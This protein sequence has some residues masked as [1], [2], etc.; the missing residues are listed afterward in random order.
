MSPEMIDSLKSGS[1]E[2]GELKPIRMHMVPGDRV[3]E[4]GT[5]L[6]FIT[7]FCAKIVGDRNVFTFEANPENEAHIRETFALNGMSPT[8]Q[9]GILSKEAGEAELFLEPSL[10]STSVIQRSKQARRIVVPKIN[11]NDRVREIKPTFLVI[12]IEGAEYD[13]TGVIDFHTASKVMIELHPYIIGPEKSQAVRD[14][15]ASAGFRC[16]WEENDHMLYVREMTA[17]R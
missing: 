1:Y 2:G 9:I 4:I 16:V 7:L 8:L 6:G 11:L 14:R 13:L 15:F 5:G 3:M 12:D 17:D 10:W